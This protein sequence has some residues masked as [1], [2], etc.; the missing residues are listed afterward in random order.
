MINTSV[1]NAVCCLVFA[2]G[3]TWCCY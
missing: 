2:A 1:A 3:E